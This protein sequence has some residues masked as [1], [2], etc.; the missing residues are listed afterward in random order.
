MSR[1][2]IVMSQPNCAPCVE[3]KNYL[4][5]KGIQYTEIDIRKNP[6]YIE[7]YDIMST[8]VTVL[9]VDEFEEGRVSGFDRKQLEELLND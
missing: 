2:V 8:P 9:E 4:D 6:K 5:S 1:E 7:V 3:V